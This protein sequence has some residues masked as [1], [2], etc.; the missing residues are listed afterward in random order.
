[1]LKNVKYVP[2]VVARGKRPGSAIQREYL[3]NITNQASESS[4]PEKPEK[5]GGSTTRGNKQ[6]SSLLE[7]EHGLEQNPGLY[8]LS[9]S[10][11]SYARILIAACFIEALTDLPP[12]SFVVKD[13]ADYFKPKIQVE[14]DNPDKL[15]TVT[16]IHIKSWKIEKPMME[17]LCLCI[18]AIDQLHTIK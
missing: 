9:K 13:P 11:S 8:F 15:D 10:A 14:M 6:V 3:A 7:L 16:E 18:P 1:M 12:K 4:K 2:D 17:I 5:K